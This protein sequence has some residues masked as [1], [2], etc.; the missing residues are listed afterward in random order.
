MD[1][2]KPYFWLA[3]WFG[4]GFI[5]PAPGT[6]GTL[7]GL[8]VALFFFHAFGI[9]FY[10]VAATAII[11]IGFWAV[12]EYQAHTKTHDAKEIV[13]DEVAGIFIALIPAF[14]SW[15]LIILAFALFRALDIWKP[16]PI[17]KVDKDHSN[18]DNVMLDDIY[19]G[20]ATAIIIILID[21]GWSM[22]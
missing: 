18:P 9:L 3:T 4:C 14:S 21:F 1:F 19:A 5:N 8:L 2:H 15:L 7:G 10:L 20:V 12:R 17:G 6:W 16:G 22:I 11:A 13:I